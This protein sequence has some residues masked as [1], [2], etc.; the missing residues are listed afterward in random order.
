MRQAPR[1]PGENEVPDRVFEDR[2]VADFENVVQVRLV[3]AGP[4]SGERHVTDAPRHLDQLLA[5]DFGVGLPA[6]AVVGEEAIELGSVHGLPADQV[7]G[8][9]AEDANVFG[10]VERVHGARS[11]CCHAWDSFPNNFRG[12]SGGRGRDAVSWRGG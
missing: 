4:R 11:R 12:G 10:G 9:L 3:A 1:Y 2:A 8:R 5:G 7:N 6:D